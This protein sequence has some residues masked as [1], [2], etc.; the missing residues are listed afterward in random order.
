[1]LSAKSLLNQYGLKPKKYMGQNFL[2]D[3]NTAEKIVRMSGIDPDD[4]VIEIGPG[5]GALTIPLAKASS[6]VWAI[7]K[8]KDLA[9][10]LPELLE[11]NGISN[12]I[13]TRADFMRI[14]LGNAP[15]DITTRPWI[16]GNLP[17]NISSPVIFRILSLREK[18]S[19]AVLMLQQELAERILAGPGSRLY[20]RISVMVGFYAKAIKLFAVP[21]H[22]F[23]PKPRVDSMIIRL[24]FP[25]EAKY[26]VNNEAFFAALVKAA[27][28]KRRK[29]IKNA[30]SGLAG[31]LDQETL[32]S[33]LLDAG[34]DPGARAETIGVEMFARLSNLLSES[35]GSAGLL[36]PPALS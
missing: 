6:L 20:G 13:V 14:D 29:T 4:T 2:A 33:V 36:Q 5:L 28:L 19:G 18:I 12:V 25:C 31:G 34:I 27:F 35:A 22:L 30:L 3:P 10:V 24:E 1:M 21:S 7:E 32:K 11:K 26:A 9:V 16:F 23:F 17:Y 8:D 15:F